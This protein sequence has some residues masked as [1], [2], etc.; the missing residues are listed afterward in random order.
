MDFFTGDL[1]AKTVGN[2]DGQLQASLTFWGY[3]DAIEMDLDTGEIF[4]P[5]A[6]RF[7]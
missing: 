7:E 1:F 6:S 4:T 2:N 5:Y 3:L